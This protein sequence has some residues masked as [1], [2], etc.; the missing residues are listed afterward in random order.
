[1][2]RYLTILLL[3]LFLTGLLPRRIGAQ[4]NDL[5]KASRLTVE[6]ATELLKRPGA[7]LLGITELSPDTAAALSQY[8]GA[9]QL[10]KLASLSPAAAKALSPLKGKLSLPALKELPPDVANA[11]APHAGMLDLEGVKSLSDASAAALAKHVGEVS[12]Q[13]QIGELSPELAAIL[14]QFR[15]QISLSHLTS[16]SPAAAKALA[17][18][19]S[20]L[21]L[22]GIK[23]APGPEISAEAAEILASYSGEL[24]VGGL[25]KLT[26]LPL[27]RK[28]GQNR[29]VYM[30]NM[31][32]MSA[33]IA[34][35][36]CPPF[37]R[38]GTSRENRGLQLTIRELPAEVAKAFA[39]RQG[40]EIKLHELSKLSD[41]AA[42]AFEG[43]N[44]QL[45]LYVSELSPAA[46]KSLA[47]VKR[48]VFFVLN[49]LSPEAELALAASKGCM[50]PEGLRR[51][52]TG[53]LAVRLVDIT[54]FNSVPFGHDHMRTWGL[55][56]CEHLSA[57]A[58]LALANASDKQVPLEGL[59]ELTS[60]PLAAKLAAIH[61]NLELTKLTE[62]S[63]DVAKAL[64]KHKGKLKLSGLK[65]LSTEAAKALASH[66]G[67]LMLDGIQ[68]LSAEADK[69][70]RANPGISLPAKK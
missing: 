38:T 54:A 65:S 1:M 31:T 18:G 6:Q 13:L 67:E 48:V 9:I 56:R 3:G 44:G 14:S 63:V 20:K 34:R 28:L 12:L 40:G 33:E 26:S 42:A 15:G 64:S 10:S 41:E 69:A 27:A 23:E 5:A 7:L 57:E 66:E 61:P 59:K 4:D 70:L 45:T 50:E 16:L 60:V 35:A 51:V 19:K 32:G 46:A 25:T 29:V 68:S 43:Y 22:A 30:G 8:K 36:L 11:L 47:S 53:P 21:V 17:P 58:A 2:S 62:I 55:K 24:H 39:V 52:N 49:Q 37:D